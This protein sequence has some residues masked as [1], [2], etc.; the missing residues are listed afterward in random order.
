MK[1]NGQSGLTGLWKRNETLILLSA[2]ILFGSMII[3][4]ILGGTLDPYLSGTLQDFH[5]QI[6]GGTLQLTTFSIFMN[7]FKVAGIIYL[8]GFSLGIFSAY[9]L[10][11]EGVFTGYT[12]SKFY[13]PTFLI[14]TI[15]HGIFEIPAIIIAG[16]AGFRLASGFYNF[17]KGV[18]KI[19]DNLPISS[20]LGYLIE[21]NS[22]EFVDSL[23]LFTIAVGLLIIA[24][25]IEA[26]LTIPWGN[27]IR[28]IT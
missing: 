22:D 21:A 27:Y 2:L 10:F 12:A 14:Y 25:F 17:L 26:N 9:F 23:K 18:T 1:N 3:A 4:Y 8:T 6:A 15:P 19:N 13:L 20:Q 28:S 24:A 16:A 11:F 7:N 5:R